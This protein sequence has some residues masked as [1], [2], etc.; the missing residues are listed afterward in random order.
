MMDDVPID[1]AG[2]MAE[3]RPAGPDDLPE[4]LRL[5]REFY[6]E[7]GFATSDAELERNFRALLAAPS[8]HTA[9]A[10][11]DGSRVGFAL[12]TAALILE[13]GLVAELQDL[14]V[15]PAHR[16]QGIAGRLIEDSVRWAREQGAS[17]LEVCVAPNGRDVSHLFTYYAGLGFRD[18]G[19]RLLRLEF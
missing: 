9:L 17:Q 8:A 7:D 15:M 6:D 3:L 5:T 2:S 19:R 10:V 13:S 14:Y 1:S 4:L 16:R 11:R 18:E 12:T